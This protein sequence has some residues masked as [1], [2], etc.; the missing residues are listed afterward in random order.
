METF[1]VNDKA[2]Q[3]SKVLDCVIAGQIK[4]TQAAK[5]LKVCR[6]TV[7]RLLDPY[8][9]EGIRALVSRRLGKPSNRSFAQTF[10]STV[11][12]IAEQDIL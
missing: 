12:A 10:K 2:L 11:K 6:K 3:R 8:R 5:E 4:Q 9:K 7:K 1:M